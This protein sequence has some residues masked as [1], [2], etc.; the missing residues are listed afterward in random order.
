MKIDDEGQSKIFVDQEGMA[1]IKC[2]VCSKQKSTRVD[3]SVI[4]DK[5]VRENC[6]VR[7]T[8]K[9]RFAVKLEFRKDSRKN[10]KLN[11][12]YLCFPKGKPR[13]KLT[14]VNVS[15]NGL[16]VEVASTDDFH[17]GDEILVLFTLDDN[18]DSLI[19][20]KAIVRS[21]KPDYIGCEFL[22]S[23]S[24]GKAFGDFLASK[25]EDI[26]EVEE[27]GEVDEKDFDWTGSFLR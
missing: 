23:S 5:E 11:G 6:M 16:G 27:E 15:Q 14:V 24:P 8:C 26:T 10:S 7:C 17:I 1:V 12:E 25:S 22:D 18:I 19:E 13:G 20:K 9:T 3:P 4:R 21:I 2:P